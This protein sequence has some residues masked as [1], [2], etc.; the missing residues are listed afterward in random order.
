[1]KL[2]KIFNNFTI[3][4]F[5]AL[6]L[7][8]FYSNDNIKKYDK[9]VLD[10][11][12]NSIHLMLKNDSFRYF[13]HGFE[14]KEQLKKDKNYF[15]TGRDNFTKYLFPRIIALYYKVF[16]YNLYEDSDKKIVKLGIHK[17]FLFFQVLIYY[18]S[19]YF[20]YFQL[21][22]K[23]EN[24]FLFFSLFFLCFEPTIFQYH[25]SFWS[26]SIFFSLQI[27]IMALVLN[28][29]SSNLR[30]FI[31]GILLSLLALQRSNGFY[32]IFPVILYF[33]FMKEFILY[34][35]IPVM[36]LGFILVINFVG[37]H[38][39]KKT[40]KYF[41][42]PTETKSVLH[43]YIVPNILNQK[44]LDIEKNKFLKFAKEKEILIDNKTL[45]KFSYQRYSFIFCQNLS[46]DNK[47]FNNF[48]LCNYFDKRSKEIIFNN[49]VKTIKFI[50]R[51]SLSY[52]LLNPLHIYS[53][54]K[55]LS[56]EEYYRSDLHK[57]LIPLRI[58]YS[59]II[60]MIC[61]IGF[62]KL[63]QIKDKKLFLYI[64]ISSIYFYC[65]LSWHGNNRYFTPV[66]I[67]ASFFFGLGVNTIYNQSKLLFSKS[68]SL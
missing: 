1:M 8:L 11:N 9:N 62:I 31:I 43:A 48:E 51:K 42:I 65:I 45:E 52:S 63:L 13:S 44:E 22:D 16:D 3:L 18:L 10:Q 41:I 28:H 67:Y 17:N 37:F 35:K 46:D 56:G 57:E 58:I 40:G 54:H 21:K 12:G 68:D 61:L 7:S 25:G 26:E 59:L 23:L 33:Y 15:D 49:P 6:I 20:L 32:Y 29:K 39:Y 60:Y 5:I 64:F 19:I 66:L 27:L 4:I 50:A 24:K 34:K 53:D 2:K 14:I 38:N 30:L 47:L 55:F 36:L